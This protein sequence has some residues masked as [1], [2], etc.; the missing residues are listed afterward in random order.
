MNTTE[1]V[2]V[3]ANVRSRMNDVRI[4]N[5]NVIDINY[6]LDRR[7]GC[8]VLPFTGGGVLPSDSRTA[9]RPPVLHFPEPDCTR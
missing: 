1:D 9:S 2:I 5:R 7:Q 4:R 3:L 8:R 6:L